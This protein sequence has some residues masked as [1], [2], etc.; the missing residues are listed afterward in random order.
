MLLLKNFSREGRAEVRV[1]RSHQLDRV[2]PDTGAQLAIGSSATSL[3]D[4]RTSSAGLVSR[5]EAE[6]LPHP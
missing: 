2:L 6:C 4:Q 5:R 3:V 1:L